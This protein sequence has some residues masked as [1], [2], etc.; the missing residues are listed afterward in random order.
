MQVARNN[1]CRVA[2]TLLRPAAGFHSTTKNSGMVSTI[3]T[4][5][6]LG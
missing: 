6:V 1:L 5:G 3:G 2:P 4:L